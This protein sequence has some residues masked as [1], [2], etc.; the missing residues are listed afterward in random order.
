MT[1]RIRTRLIVFMQAIFLTVLPAFSGKGYW[2]FTG[3]RLFKGEPFFV[4]LNDPARLEHGAPAPEPGD[5]GQD[6]RARFNSL[7]GTVEIRMDPGKAAWE[8]ARMEDVLK[9][10]MHIRTLK[11]GS[12]IIQFE[13]M[14]SYVMPP[15]TEII[16]ESPPAPD[17]KMSLV[18]GRLWTNLKKPLARGAMEIETTRAIAG[19]RGIMF[20]SETSARGDRVAVWKGNVEVT[21]KRLGSTVTILAG[22]AVRITRDRFGRIETLDMDDEIAFWMRYL[23]QDGL[24]EATAAAA[25]LKGR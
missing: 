13:E 20:V 5:F 14:D 19:I 10:G 25:A 2:K 22:Q 18:T 4:C 1:I 15:N 3:E 6:A 23:S 17:G 9:A 11:D 8:A 24:R 21:H 7:T 16:I 12:C